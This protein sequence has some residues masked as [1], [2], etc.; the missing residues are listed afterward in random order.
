MAGC[1]GVGCCCCCC[2]C[3]D[4]VDSLVAAG[5]L[6]YK[7]EEDS[8]LVLGDEYSPLDEAGAAAGTCGMVLGIV[9]GTS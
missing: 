4:G 6:E 8:G 2:C 9:P 5:G 1:E 7:R 3:C